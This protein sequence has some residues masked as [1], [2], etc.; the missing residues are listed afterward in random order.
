MTGILRNRI[1]VHHRNEGEDLIDEARDRL[2]Q[3]MLNPKS[4]DGKGLRVDST[5]ESPSVQRT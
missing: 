4:A 1:G 2:I 5:R 3:A